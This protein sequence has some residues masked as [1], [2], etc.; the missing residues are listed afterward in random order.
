M[1]WDMSD[2][3]KTAALFASLPDSLA[4]VAELG[5]ADWD[6]IRRL[7][8]EQLATIAR[9]CRDA[10]TRYSL[11]SSA[12]FSKIPNAHIALPTVAAVFATHYQAAMS[13]LV[14]ER[15]DHLAAGTV[16]PDV[17]E[18]LADRRR[19]PQ[20]KWPDDLFA[21]TR[22]TLAIAT[23]GLF[24]AWTLAAA[25]RHAPRN[26]DAT[27]LL[28]YAGEAMEGAM[29][30]FEIPRLI[31]NDA[32]AAFCEHLAWRT[33]TGVT[34]AIH[35]RRPPAD[36]TSVTF[37][38]LDL[39]DIYR[40]A[41]RDQSLK[42]VYGM[43]IA[44]AFE[45]QLALLFTSLGFTVIESTP[46]KRYIDLLCI[47]DAPS[48]VTVL[49]EAK[50]TKAYEYPFRADDQRALAEHVREVQRTLRNLPPLQ[51][52]LIVAPRFSSGADRRISDVSRELSVPC[53]GFPTELLTSL[54]NDHL[55]P[56]PI[57]VALD[58]I[59]AGPAIVDREVVDRVLRIAASATD[60]WTQ[61]VSIQ[62]VARE[63][64]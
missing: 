14:V 39:S 23:W 8:R 15:D 57:D 37:S 17:F 24:G 13:K 12:S 28:S 53:H 27:D 50:S 34:D 48:P 1:M 21:A 35:A 5:I 56:L 32:M 16:H 30:L 54:R 26:A 18:A 36:L 19:P 4:S 62:R 20:G 63:T 7:P 22:L 64:P 31:D 43:S 42:S 10:L 38:A 40:L 44:R 59:R 9:P 41:R 25:L 3:E 29:A 11:A 45:R 61:F 47:A 60:A 55:G 52:V 58:Q 46:G 51:L 33:A 49:V 6:G 2:P